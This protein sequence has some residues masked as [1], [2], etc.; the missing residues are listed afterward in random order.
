M[1]FRLSAS[2]RLNFVGLNDARDQDQA[3]LARKR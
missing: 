2:F 1:E 3:E